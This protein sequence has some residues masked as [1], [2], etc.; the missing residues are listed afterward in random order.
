MLL[1]NLGKEDNIKRLLKLGRSTPEGLQSNDRIIDQLLDLFVKGADGTYNKDANFDYLSY[2][3]ADI[4]KHA[5]GRAYFLQKQAYDGV[6]PLTKLTVF[7][8]HRSTVRRKGVAST[9]KNV[10]FETDKHSLFLAADEI[11]ILPYLLLPITGGEEYSDEDMDG[12]LDDLQLLPPDKEREADVDV[13]KTHVETLTLLTTTREGRDRLRDV[14][15]YPV[16]RETHLAVED[17][18][19]REAC[20][21]LVQVLMRDEEGEEV[22]ENMQMLVRQ[23]G[24]KGVPQA[25]AGGW[26]DQEEEDDEIEEV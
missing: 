14:K 3:F 16:I 26:A 8:E 21:R 20:E 24:K 19:V 12:M 9:I 17:D 18:G 7:T 22:S 10:A 15:V 4:A 25:R 6:I 1:A 23:P 2:L 11:N 13:V 5:E